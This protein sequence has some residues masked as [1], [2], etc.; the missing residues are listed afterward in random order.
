MFFHVTHFIFFLCFPSQRLCSIRT[1]CCGQAE[2]GGQV[3]VEYH[4]SR[5]LP[6]THLHPSHSHFLDGVFRLVLRVL[7]EALTQ[8]VFLESPTTL[9]N[10]E[11]QPS[12]T[13]MIAWEGLIALC[14]SKPTGSRPKHAASYKGNTAWCRPLYTHWVNCQIKLKEIGTFRIIYVLLEMGHKKTNT[15][16]NLI[17]QIT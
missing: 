8:A 7:T 17:V 15:K 4:Q 13:A 9:T 12:W 3:C 2:G 5:D 10:S 11:R 1:L 16:P 6:Q 14:G